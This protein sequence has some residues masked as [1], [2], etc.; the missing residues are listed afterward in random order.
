MEIK[1]WGKV[2]NEKIY[3]YT[4]T[5]KN[6]MKVSLSNIGAA[7]QSVFVKDKKKVFKDVVL[8]YD[9]LDGYLNDPF[10]MGTV[11]GRYANRIAGGKVNIDG[12]TYQL[13]VK[14]GGF[15]HHGGESRI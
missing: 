6:G 11:V 9:S 12:E 4:I 2:G 5:N 13:T 1:D 14:D 10:Y 15:H 7:I 3:L 8:G